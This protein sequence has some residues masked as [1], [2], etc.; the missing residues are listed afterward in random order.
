MAEQAERA[1][2]FFMPPKD[3]GTTNITTYAPL[4]DSIVSINVSLSQKSRVIYQ[5]TLV[6][7]YIFGDAIVIFRC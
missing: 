5:L 6:P 1:N 2:I 4:F 7:K 3:Q